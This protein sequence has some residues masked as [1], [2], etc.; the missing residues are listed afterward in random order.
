MKKL[1]LIV[2]I[3]VFILL[4]IP[5][6]ILGFGYDGST[7]EN[8]D[9]SIYDEESD[10]VEVFY[11]S[12]EQALETYHDHDDGDEDLVITMH[13]D[14]INQLIYDQF[15][16]ENESYAP[17]TSCESAECDSA[18]IIDLNDTGSFALKVHGAWVELTSNSPG[19][20]TLNVALEMGRLDG[21]GYKTSLQIAFEFEDTEDEYLVTFDSIR[22]GRLPLTSGM[23]TRIIGA[24]G[25]ESE[26][27]EDEFIKIDM[28]NLSASIDKMGMI[29]I[30]REEE[31][32][33]AM[34]VLLGE[35]LAIIYERDLLQFGVIESAMDIR[36]GVSVFRSADDEDIPLYLYDMHDEVGY[37]PELFNASNFMETRFEEYVF[38]RALSGE[39]RYK[40]REVHLN[41]IV[42]DEFEGFED[43][44]MERMVN[45]RLMV[46]GLS[47]MWFEF[48][49][50]DITVH[51]LMEIDSIKSKIIM[52]WE[53]T[54]QTDREIEYDLSSVSI[55]SREDKSETDYILINEATDSDRL[56]KFRAFFASIGDVEFVMFDEAGTLHLEADRLESFMEAGTIED[57][58]S[59]ESIEVVE[60]GIYL[61]LTASNETLD[62]VLSTF[63]SALKDVFESPTIISDLNG[64][65]N[66]EEGSDEALLI[67]KVES[68]Q[69][70]L[71]TDGTTDS[72]N[73]DE[74]FNLYEQ[75]DESS[76]TAFMDTIEGSIDPNI[77][78]EFNEL[79]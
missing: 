79:F 36:F 11:E 30:L 63:G 13:Q 62:T 43:F 54:N 35:M 7:W 52:E 39:T 19:I 65:L 2:F 73:V 57:N 74:M 42:Y 53:I 23:A 76:Q 18:T 41:K 9:K 64:A 47:A 6:L 40:L 68:I 26:S 55:G 38:D 72:E 56:E 24:L 45:D 49:E 33:D 70:D 48:S 20:M 46:V 51:A 34:F 27:D 21:F 77:F 17:Q 69:S 61:A 16:N 58:L 15:R 28:N 5:A 31:N 78:E 25:V 60:E 66:P 67:D 8:F 10:G 32:D 44:R 22:L 59:I 14:I 37:N 50:T 29:D 71:N 3:P 4:S 12:L 75:L 1:L